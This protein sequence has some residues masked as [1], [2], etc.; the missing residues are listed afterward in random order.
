[1]NN[2]ELINEL[3]AF[4]W[5]LGGFTLVAVCAYLVNINDIREIDVYKLATIF[6]VS[7]SG[8][9]VNRITKRLNK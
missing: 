5:G 7:A 6:V 8:Y 1:M 3:K 2:E 9:I 4:A